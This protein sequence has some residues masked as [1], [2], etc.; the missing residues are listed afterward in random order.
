M[1]MSIIVGDNNNDIIVRMTALMTNI[2]SNKSNNNNR[3]RVR[4]TT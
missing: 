2:N 3:N 4:N 1:V